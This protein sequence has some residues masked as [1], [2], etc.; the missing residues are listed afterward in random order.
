MC[1]PLYERHRDTPPALNRQP[2]SE[3][4]S[5]VSKETAKQ[6]L[7][8]EGNA[9]HRLAGLVGEE[10]ERAEEIIT[11]ATGRVIVSGLGKS[12]IIARK[13]AATLTS[14][15]I[16]SFF[17]HPVEAAHGD[18]GMI[19]RGDVAIIISKSGATDELLVLINHLKRIETPIIAMTGNTQSGLAQA[20][21]VILDVSVER[22]A[23]PI[24]TVPTA[25][26]TAALAMGD[27]LAV[28][29]FKRK[30]LTEADFAALH[31][32]GSIGR[33]LTY[34]VR[35]LMVSGNDLPLVDIATPMNGVIDEMSARKLG[36]AVITDNG[37]LAGVITDGDLR[38]LLQ[39]V[40]RPLELN[41]GEAMV[42][43]TREGM[44]RGMPLTID[45]DTYVGRAVSIME[46]HIVTTLVVVG[47]DNGP[48]GL[49]R[50]IDLSTAGVV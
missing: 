40:E 31:P 48:V 41:A 13:I 29:I 7:T 5:A 27:A 33:K 6:V 25:S 45:P 11:S 10:F 9:L 26:T 19:G 42:R 15:G 21:E 3:K 46:R 34:R 32:G 17:L 22:E 36:I 4:Q 35:D 30:G 43:S 50:W 24:N 18:I 14:I 28:S 23:C 2:Q 38:R 37:R 8:I 20:A 1:R 12:G 39:R 47:E 44:E 16:Q 49:I